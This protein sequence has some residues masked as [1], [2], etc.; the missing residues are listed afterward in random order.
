MIWLEDCKFKNYLLLAI[1]SR[2]P[3]GGMGFGLLLN[4]PLCL[5]ANYSQRISQ[6]SA[7]MQR[8]VT[9]LSFN[10]VKWFTLNIRTLK[11]Q[12]RTCCT[13]PAGGEQ[14]LMQKSKRKSPW[15]PKTRKCRW[16][17]TLFFLAASDTSATSL[18][19]PSS[20]KELDKCWR[21]KGGLN[22]FISLISWTLNHEKY[23]YYHHSHNSWA[24][25][26]LMAFW[27]YS[28]AYC[29]SSHS[30]LHEWLCG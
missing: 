1:L 14:R 15:K 8:R 9:I 25:Y 4:A 29:L 22:Y 21:K 2:P 28:H 6:S 12:S 23:N 11:L 19:Q 18:T 16:W 20:L 27:L 26:S 24:R 10:V 3:P 7:E 30:P 17:K 13:Q 5:I